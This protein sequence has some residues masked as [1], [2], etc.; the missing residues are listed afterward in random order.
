M[1]IAIERCDLAIPIVLTGT[2]TVNTMALHQ[3]CIGVYMKG[4]VS[5]DTVPFLI[6]G[7]V[8]GVAKLDGTGLTWTAGQILYWDDT[9]EK[10]FK[11]TS[12]G[13]STLAN[14]PIAYSAAGATATT[15]TVEL[16]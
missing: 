3:N 2:V 13:A 6:K 12:T 5:N 15:G 9:T 14:T 4:G 16:I 8:S 11:T 1:A 10:E 7:R